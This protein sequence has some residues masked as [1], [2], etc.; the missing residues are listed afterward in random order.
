MIS[1]TNKE[2][3][4][5]IVGAMAL[6]LPVC[7]VP[8]AIVF[9]ADF[10]GPG[11]SKTGS[12]YDGVT[13]G[14][15]LSEL[16]SNAYTSTKLKGDNPM[17]ADGGYLSCA[18]ST[19]FTLPATS[20]NAARFT[21]NSAAT[22]MDAMTSVT[23]GDRVINGGLD[24]F[25]R[26]DKNITKSEL[27]AVDL[28]NRG[29]G[30][31]RFVFASSSPGG[32]IL[33]VLSNDNGLLSGSEGGSTGKVLSVTGPFQMVSNTVY[34]LGLTFATDT[35]GTV[36]AKLWGQA[37]TN[38]IDLTTATPV[39]TLTFGINEAVVTNGF[40]NGDFYLGQIR[41]ENITPPM[42]QEFDQFRIYNS[43]PTSFGALQAPAA[44][45]PDSKPAIVLQADFNGAG[46][47]TGGA[48]DIVALGGTAVLTD[49]G[50]YSDASV[51]DT[52]P[53]R[54]FSKGYLSI[55]TTNNT[56]GGMYGRA[57]ITPASAGN[58]L[59][60]MNA[61]TNNQ[62]GIRG[63]FDFFFRADKN[64]NNAVNSE[65]RP[66]DSDNRNAGGLRLAL[67]SYTPTQ[68]AL[69][70]LA[71][72]GSLGLFSGGEGGTPVTSFLY[73]FNGQLVSNT[74]YHVGVSFSS[75]DA[76]NVTAATWL[77][78]GTGA[79][80]LRREL[81]AGAV[82]F[83][84]NESVVTNGFSAGVIDFGKL[85][86]YG[87]TPSKQE[88]DTFRIYKDVPLIFSELPSVPPMGTVIRIF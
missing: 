62:R 70:L 38:A 80:D 76:G 66:I 54:L 27:R 25:F 1:L 87:D 20:L 23:N 30:G 63:G 60:A 68:M 73:P 8:A 84:I 16:Y 71:P 13:T 48:N 53:F 31:L 85:R 86:Q 74:L 72:V 88:F 55:L 22:S 65:F 47:G 59:A 15:V 77:K 82:T 34:H 57:V 75:D 64:I 50:T 39:A 49:A 18:I 52:Q 36:T 9:Q 45:W 28:D 17:A 35:E 26:S 67:Y 40:V 21:P 44:A 37:G 3:A 83:G 29:K 11:N 69:E 51:T 4:I 81:P 56:A 78:E 79:I 42:T 24:F 33:E 61:V 46:N 19:N 14:G 5:F 43:T 2:T 6:C 58:S 12:P 41:Y 7:R 32:L 10:S